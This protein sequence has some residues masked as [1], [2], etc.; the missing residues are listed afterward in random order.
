MQQEKN[1]V[2][3]MTICRVKN[4]RERNKLINTIKEIQDVV[5]DKMYVKEICLYKSVLRPEGPEYEKLSRF[6]LGDV[7]V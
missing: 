1:P 6:K 5:L 4:V 2:P 3:H 7:N